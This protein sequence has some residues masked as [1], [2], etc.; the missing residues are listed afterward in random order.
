MTTCTALGLGLRRAWMQ[1]TL[2]TTQRIVH[3]LAHEHSGCPRQSQKCQS[4]YTQSMGFVTSSNPGVRL[5]VDKSECLMDEDIAVKVTG[6]SP[7]ERV[8]VLATMDRD[9]NIFW[10]HGLFRANDCGVVDLSTDSPIRGSYDE[11]DPMGLIWSMVAAPWLPAH[12][13]MFQ[14]R[15][16]K[17]RIITFSVFPESDSPSDYLT[18]KT[19]LLASIEHKR[20]YKSS[21]TRRI[22]IDHPRLQGTV[23]LPEGPGPF[24]GVIEMY[25]GLVPI[26]EG[27]AALL[28]SRGF[29]TLSLSYVEGKGLPQTMVNFELSYFEEAAK[30]FASLPAVR[31]D[32][33][34]VLSLSLGGTMALWMAQTIP[35]IRAVVNI[36]GMPY[37]HRFW[38]HNGVDIGCKTRTDVSLIQTNHEGMSVKYM[39]VVHDDSYLKPWS[40]GANL[41]T[42]SGGDDLMTRMEHNIRFYEEFMPQDY[43]QKKTEFVVYPGAGH[44]IHLPNTPLCRVVEGADK[45][46]EALNMTNPKHQYNNLLLSGGYPKEHAAAQRGAWQR[47]LNFLRKH[48]W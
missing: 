33:L 25:G 39:F 21:N 31:S 9:G 10:S 19:K 15:A 48:L 46:Q 13:R 14:S 40:H 36:N 20:W 38:T 7:N 35:N 3:L 30:W 4:T 28:A 34:G 1:P 47:S 11:T 43:R 8:T 37:T 23:F 27:R 2:K 41:L 6:L 24:P 26:V 45:I 17:P 44:L 22:P 29:A 5:G 32:G 12:T 16:I 42:I 18:D